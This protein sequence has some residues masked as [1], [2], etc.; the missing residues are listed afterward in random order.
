MYKT[1]VT[2]TVRFTSFDFW[3]GQ[4]RVETLLQ[5]KLQPYTLTCWGFAP[6]S[7]KAKGTDC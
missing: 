1:W 7:W 2:Y 5:R 3:Q 6:N 4:N